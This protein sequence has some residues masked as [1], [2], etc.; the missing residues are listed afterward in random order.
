MCPPQ[1]RTAA[2]PIPPDRL[3]LPPSPLLGWPL[4]SV[5]D[6]Y[7]LLGSYC[8]YTHLYGTRMKTESHSIPVLPGFYQLSTKSNLNLLRNPHIYNIYS[9]VPMRHHYLN[10]YNS[11]NLISCLL[12]PIY[13]TNVY[14]LPC[15]PMRQLNLKVQ[16]LL[17]LTIS[18]SLKHFLPCPPYKHMICFV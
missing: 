2:C 16:A 6:F 1:T 14:R 11:Y 12:L 17:Y 18:C 15:S 4:T 3:S 9:E 7:K 10:R 13:Y 8:A 5:H